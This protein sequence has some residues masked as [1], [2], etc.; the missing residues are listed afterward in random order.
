MKKLALLL[1]LLCSSPLWAAQCQQL[2]VKNE[3]H[4]NG[5]DVEVHTI[6]GQTAVMDH[7]NDLYLAGEKQTLTPEQQ[8]AVASYRESITRALPKARQLAH[9]GLALANDI[10]DDVAASIH[11]PQAFEGVKQSMREFIA[12]IEARYNKEGDWVLPANTFASMSQQWQQD[13][14]KARALFTEKFLTG[15]FDAIATRMKQEG[16]VNLTELGNTMAELKERLEQR[17]SEHSQLIEKERRE[18]CD[19]LD[20]MVEQEQQLQQKIPELK[21]YQVFTI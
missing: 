6:S 9:D 8:Q 21:N 3:L 10:L 13:F 14:D 7:N 19:S 2:D 16:G 12:D 1:S 17:F 11:S 18:L 20:E 15:A 4:L 5:S